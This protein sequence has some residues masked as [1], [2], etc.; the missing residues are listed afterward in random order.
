MRI[1]SNIIFRNL[2]KRQEQVCKINLIKNRMNFQ[3]SLTTRKVPNG[4]RKGNIAYIRDGTDAYFP[5]IN[6]CLHLLIITECFKDFT[7][8]TQIRGGLTS[9]KRFTKH[10]KTLRLKQ[11]HATKNYLFIFY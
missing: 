10:N 1:R 7:F 9:H 4:W 8:Y 6:R 11:A 2:K 3:Y 5:N